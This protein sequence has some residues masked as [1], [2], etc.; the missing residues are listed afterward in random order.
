MKKSNGFTLLEVMIALTIFALMATTLSQTAAITVDN[1]IH[2]ERKLLATWVAE[3]EIIEL[4]STP[5][6][7]IKSA[8]KD[9]NYAERD[10]IISTV[11]TPKKQLP[12]MPGL[13]LDIKSIIVSVS[14]KESP[15]DPLQ[16]LTAYV[17]ND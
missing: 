2:I 12:G 16:S 8:K 1:Q 14:L 6:A 10:W 7:N 5:F 15:E 11:V 13:V 17:A 4:R 3:N 9:I